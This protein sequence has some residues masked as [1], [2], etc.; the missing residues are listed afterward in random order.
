MQYY[1]RSKKFYTI[2]TR[3]YKLR[4]FISSNNRKRMKMYLIP[5]GLFSLAFNYLA[6]AKFLVA[7]SCSQPG[8]IEVPVSE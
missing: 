6:R 8:A 5:T 2:H 3:I 1:V 7:D 4:N